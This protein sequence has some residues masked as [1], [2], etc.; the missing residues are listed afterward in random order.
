MEGCEVGRVSEISRIPRRQVKRII[1]SESDQLEVTKSLLNILYNIVIV[2]S[3]LP[4]VS[5]RAFF[6]KHSEIVLE[7]VSRSRPLHWK[8]QVLQESISLVINIAASCHTVAG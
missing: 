6:N 5:Q 8:K 3:I 7:L 1:E 4:T 2:G